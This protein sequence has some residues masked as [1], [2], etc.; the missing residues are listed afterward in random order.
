MG[1]SDSGGGG[2][3]S[4]SECLREQRMGFLNDF[5]MGMGMLMSKMMA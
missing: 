4:V 5:E 1:S 3:E 2:A